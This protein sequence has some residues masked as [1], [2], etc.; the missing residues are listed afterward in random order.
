[1]MQENIFFPGESAEMIVK[2]ESER[3]TYT[4]PTTALLQENNKTYVLVLDIE[5]TVLGQQYT[6]R[7]MEVTVE[8]KNN[9]YAAISANGISADMQIITDSD[10]SVE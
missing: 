4:I 8:D 3:Y 10:R 2:Q 9:G 5:D 7:K 6:A 1:S